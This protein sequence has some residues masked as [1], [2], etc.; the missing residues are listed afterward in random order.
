MIEDN[1]EELSKYYRSNKSNAKFR[2]EISPHNGQ[3]ILC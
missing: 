2:I 3:Q 1:F